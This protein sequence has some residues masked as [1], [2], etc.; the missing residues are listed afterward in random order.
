M[1]S[2]FSWRTKKS[3]RRSA[4][5][6]LA[7]TSMQWSCG[8][9]LA[10]RSTNLPSISSRCGVSRKKPASI[11]CSHISTV[12]RK[13][14]MPEAGQ[15][16]GACKVMTV[17]RSGLVRSA[18]PAQELLDRVED[19]FLVADLGEGQVGHVL[20]GLLELSE[21]LARAV[22]ALDLAVAE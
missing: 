17:L 22:R 16:G 5:S 15:R 11:I 10:M 13:C 21:E 8:S 12:N 7:S 9:R 20:E 19:P 18:T 4:S 6:R 1:Q 3:G 2:D 14:L